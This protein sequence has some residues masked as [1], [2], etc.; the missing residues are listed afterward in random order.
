MLAPQSRHELDD[1]RLRRHVERAHGLVTNQHARFQDHRARDANSL[2]LLPG[3][4]VRNRWRFR[5]QHLVERLDG[6]RAQRS[7]IER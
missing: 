6:S 4:L 5:R 1:L 7:L 3:K 2:T